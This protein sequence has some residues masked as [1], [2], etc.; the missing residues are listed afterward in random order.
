MLWHGLPLQWEI[1]IMKTF[2][3]DITFI[4]KVATQ[5]DGKT[6]IEWVEEEVTKTGTFK[7]LVRTDRDQHKLH[8]KLMSMID[9]FRSEEGERTMNISTDGLYD[10]SVKAINTLLVIDKD[11]NAEDKKEFLSDSGAILNF[12]LWLLKDKIEPFFLT[13]KMT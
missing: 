1:N 6:E 13:L 2:T 3:R 9:V 5:P 8:F 7:Q 10:I 12:G 4:S 11:F